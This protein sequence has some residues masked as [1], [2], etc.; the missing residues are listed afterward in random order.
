MKKIIYLLISFC[1]LS[2]VACKSDNIRETY[3]GEDGVATFAQKII[4]D[5]EVTLEATDYYVPI[6]RQTNVGELTVNFATNPYSGKIKA[7]VTSVKFADGEYET[8][9]KIDVTDIVLG[10]TDTLGI[11]MTNSFNAGISIDSCAVILARGYTWVPIG[12]GQWFDAFVE[13]PII[14]V[15]VKKADGFDIYRVYSPYPKEKLIEAGI[16]E[17]G[18]WGCSGDPCDF[19]EF[20]VDEKGGIVWEDWSTTLDYSGEGDTVYAV[21][22]PKDEKCFGKL[23]EDKVAVFY[24]F[25]YIPT[26]GGGFGVAAFCALSLPGGPDLEKWL[27]ENFG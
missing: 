15:D 17:S 27:L 20:S 5:S 11:K 9:L 26:L 16:P 14:K 3:S 22:N 25:L 24:P 2:I 19:I 4:K 7:P 8:K 18:K 12:E 13:T 21:Y 6:R 23:G 1:A 10:E